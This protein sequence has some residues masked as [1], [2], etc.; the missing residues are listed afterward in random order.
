MVTIEVL[1]IGHLH[2]LISHVEGRPAGKI[3]SR[4]YGQRRLQR[5]LDRAGLTLGEAMASAGVVYYEPGPV[6]FKDV[7]AAG[8]TAEELAA[9]LGGGGA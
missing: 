6:S 2:E 3:R 8:P 1:T 7:F 5:G 9:L 4:E